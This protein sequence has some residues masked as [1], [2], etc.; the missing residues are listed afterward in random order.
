MG[1]QLLV[2]LPGKLQLA[3]HLVL[4]FAGGG[5]LQLVI[6]LAR[7][8]C[9]QPVCREGLKLD[10]VGSGP[11]CR[12][13]QLP[14][15]FKLPLWLTPAS[16]MIKVDSLLVMIFFCILNFSEHLASLLLLPPPDFAHQSGPF[17][18]NRSTSTKDSFT[19]LGPS[20]E[21]TSCRNVTMIPN[22]NIMLKQRLGVEDAIF[23][24]FNPG[25]DQRIM[26]YYSSGSK[27]CMC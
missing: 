22:L 5:G 4:R 25:V 16:A 7:R 8:T 21:N 14:S 10:Q 23:T 3:D 17:P 6:R 24:N 13:N 18:H 15:R 2:H 12:F 9:H 11:C 26:H 27:F 20:I 19:N 1:D